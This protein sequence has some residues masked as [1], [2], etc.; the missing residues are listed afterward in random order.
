MVGPIYIHIKNQKHIDEF[1][2]KL[3]V[4]I[5]FYSYIHGPESYTLYV[6]CYSIYTL[7]IYIVVAVV[8]VY[9]HTQILPLLSDQVL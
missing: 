5:K 6:S 7:I 9:I 1:E 8:A 2:V 3:Y 4:Y